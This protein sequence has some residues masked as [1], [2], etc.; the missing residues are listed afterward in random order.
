MS[1]NIK[2]ITDRE[3]IVAIANAVRSKIGTSNELTLGEIASSISSITSSGGINTSDATATSSDILSGKTAY[4]KGTKVTGNIQSRSATTI[5]PNNSTQTIPSGIY[6]SGAQTISPVPTQEKTVTS[7]GTVTP[8][9]GKYLSKVTVNVQQTG[10]SGLDTSDATATTNDILSGKTAYVKGSKVTGSIATKTSTDLTA[11]GATVSVPSGYYASN[12]SKSVSTA[13]QATPNISVNDSGLITASATQTAGYVSSGTKSATLQLLTQGA[14]TITPSSSQQT[15]V[16]SGKYT[17]G[18]VVV[19]AVPTET[20]SITSNGT[21]SP[22]SGKYFS[23]VTVSVPDKTF[24]TQTKTVSPTTSQQTI[25]PDSGYDGLSSVTVNAIATGALSTPTVNSSGLVTANV[26][27]SGYLA[28]GTSKTLQLTTQ[29]AKTVTP[30]T[31]SQTA[32]ASGVYTT[33]AITVGAIP[34]SYVQPSGTLNIT[35][36]GTHDVTNYASASVNIQNSGGITIPSTITAGNTPV[37]VSS[38]MAHTCTSTSMTAT[39]ISVTVPRAGTYRFKFSC[40][41]TNTS[42]T[43]TAQLYKNGSAISNATATWSSYQG[44]YSGDIS[45]SANDK[46]EI[47]V[48]SR[49]TSY[50]LITG[51]LTACIN[52]DTGF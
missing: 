4:V 50:R 27:T 46:I 43:W 6:L 37:L 45:C 40:A 9:S 17:T 32:V 7:N 13:T 2:V 49:G 10:G 48:K 3:N 51:H 35:T 33:G 1:N 19:S 52:W 28:S 29:A 30:T 18:N 16:S 24:T 36:N 23:S 14:K 41:R 5:T 34:S 21:Y 12:A 42:G 44:T 47:Y 39:G 31:S 20:K 8:D 22:T 11:S 15:A 38:T 26:G 25:T